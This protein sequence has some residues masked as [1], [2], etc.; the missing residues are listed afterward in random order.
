[1]A[2]FPQLQAS[3]GSQK[4]IQ[5]LVNEKPNLLNSQ[6]R[7]NLNLTV[8]EKIT[9]HS[10]LKTDNYAEYR[11]EAFLERLEIDP[12]RVKLADFW[13]K[14]G[15]QWDAPAKSSSGK[16][17]LVEAKSHIPE[18]ISTFNG[19]NKASI[20]KVT[21]SLEETKKRFGVKT[22]FDWKKTFYQYTNRLAHLHFLEKNGFSAYLVFVYFLNDEEMNGPKTSDEWKGAIRLIHR[23]LGLRENLL[24]KFVTDIFIDVSSL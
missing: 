8:D 13:P 4:W 10:P 17:F 9:W 11:D 23:C 18:L 24:Q 16:L 21:N 2:R 5:K 12:K 6:I 1:M 7:E 14:R 22:D 19:S 15:P 3:K 20:S